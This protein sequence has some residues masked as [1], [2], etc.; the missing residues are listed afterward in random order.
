MDGEKG[1]DNLPYSLACR[2]DEAVEMLS[3]PET[4][5][6]S[7]ETPGTRE[8]PGNRDFARV[9]GTGGR[10]RGTGK[11]RQL[12][13]EPGRRGLTRPPPSHTWRGPCYILPDGGNFARSDTPELVSPKSVLNGYQ[14]PTGT[15]QPPAGRDLVRFAPPRRLA[16]ASWPG[17]GGRPAAQ[18]DWPARPLPS[19]RSGPYGW[20]HGD[21][22]QV[23]PRP[24][25]PAPRLRPGSRY[26][27]AGHGTRPCPVVNGSAPPPARPA[28]PPRSSR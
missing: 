25:S 26:Q 9:A 4:G 22:R 6:H 11:A 13:A 1:A 19:E 3:P 23:P 18:P 2:L 24:A 27:Q 7:E 8:G 15:R 10:P 12:A 28:P 5:H 21:G 17:P 14:G 20:W 16:C